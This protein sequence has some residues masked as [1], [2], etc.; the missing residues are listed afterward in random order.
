MLGVLA[1]LLLLA[2]GAAQELAVDVV[3]HVAGPDVGVDDRGHVAGG[4][5]GACRRTGLR[6]LRVS[7]LH[8]V[9]PRREV[10]VG[11]SAAGAW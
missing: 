8:V 10:L 5:G 1:P 7:D 4:A 3:R 6:L 9:E 2:L 11:A